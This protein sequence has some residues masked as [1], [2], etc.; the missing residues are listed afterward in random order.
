MPIRIITASGITMAITKNSVFYCSP[1][2]QTSRPQC[3]P[4]H[5]VICLIVSH[6]LAISNLYTTT[7]HARADCQST[8][9]KRTLFTF[10]HRSVADCLRPCTKLTNALTYA[11]STQPPSSA[12]FSPS[13]LVLERPS[14]S[15]TSK[16]RLAAIC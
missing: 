10:L 14:P 3:Q 12:S 2:K 6:I 7:Y 9:F 5:F 16:T 1:Q 13:L 15:L 11:Y 8:S 4:I